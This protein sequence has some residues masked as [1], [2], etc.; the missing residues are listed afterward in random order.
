[1]HDEPEGNYVI[2]GDDHDRIV[3]AKNAQIAALEK[4]HSEAQAMPVEMGAPAHMIGRGEGEKATLLDQ[5]CAIRGDLWRA[6]ADDPDIRIADPVVDAVVERIQKQHEKIVALETIQLA[7]EARPRCFAVA[8]ITNEHGEL[9]LIRN[10]NRGGWELP[11]GHVEKNEDPRY[12]A[13]REAWEEAGVDAVLD[14]L[15]FAVVCGPRGVANVYRGTACGNLNPGDDADDASWFTK[16]QVA[17]RRDLSDI[18]S[19]RLIRGWMASSGATLTPGDAKIWNDPHEALGC[20]VD[21]RART[22]CDLATGDPAT[23]TAMPEYDRD[24]WRA[25]EL[26]RSMRER[27]LEREAADLRAQ[28]TALE[29]GFEFLLRTLAE[30]VAKGGR[31][32][33]SMADK[34]AMQAAEMCGQIAELEEKLAAFT[35]PVDAREAAHAR[36]AAMH[37]EI[38][39]ADT[40]TAKESRV[41]TE[42]QMRHVEREAQLARGVADRERT[43]ES[44]RQRLDIRTGERDEALRQ[45]AEARAHLD[46]ETTALQYGDDDAAKAHAEAARAVVR[47]W[48]EQLRRPLQTCLH[49]IGDLVLHGGVTTCGACLEAKESRPRVGDPILRK[50]VRQAAE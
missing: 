20:D 24:S 40:W 48:Q 25:I 30:G 22:L 2:S 8:F 35:A 36:A 18:P 38:T 11:G 37:T 6:V 31:T 49:S 21:A 28:V 34:L 4:Q 5:V 29:G 23:Y 26:Q 9:L 7:L 33:E 44:L 10:K 17:V 19:A 13:K 41:W 42:A 50:G 15:P 1:M 43:I 27:G 46:A 47:E 32:P 12:A 39:G 16:E 3:A 45:L 14:P